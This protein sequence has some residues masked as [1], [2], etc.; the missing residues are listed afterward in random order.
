MFADPSLEGLDW[1][2][3]SRVEL[4]P[5]NN[6]IPADLTTLVFPVPNLAWREL[7]YGPGLRLR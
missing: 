4:D 3:S 7:Y 1:E 5:W 2:S 6:S